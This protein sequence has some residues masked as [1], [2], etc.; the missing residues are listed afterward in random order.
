[1]YCTCY[2]HGCGNSAM[3]HLGHCSQ[4]S[5]H[6]AHCM[7][8]SSATSFCGAPA[9]DQVAT[10]RVTSP[11]KPQGPSQSQIYSLRFCSSP[12]QHSYATHPPV[13]CQTINMLYTPGLSLTGELHTPSTQILQR[14]SATP[15][16]KTRRTRLLNTFRKSSLD[17]AGNPQYHAH[18]PANQ[19]F[20]AAMKADY[21]HMNT[22][23]IEST[24]QELGSITLCGFWARQQ[25]EEKPQTQASPR[26]R[27]WRV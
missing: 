2:I 25:A 19:C 3:A 13:D 10:C 16:Q 26:R 7:S 9:L 8:T 1:M 15:E 12:R 24:R 4:P 11:A 21:K 20:E 6:Q 14:V 17:I 27:R 23:A 5:R 18:Y 22:T